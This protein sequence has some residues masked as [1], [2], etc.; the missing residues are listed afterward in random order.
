MIKEKLE[1]NMRYQIKKQNIIM[2]K[3][4][5]NKQ[6]HQKWS[7]SQKG[8]FGM[9]QEVEERPR[10]EKKNTNLV[11]SGGIIRRVVSHGGI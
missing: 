10:V 3:G 4:A 1:A 9:F 5:R 11:S 8:V 2:Q 6:E 7:C